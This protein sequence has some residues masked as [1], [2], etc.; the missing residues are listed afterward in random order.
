MSYGVE[1]PGCRKWIEINK[2]TNCCKQ[3][4]INM[5]YIMLSG[6]YYNRQQLRGCTGFDGFFEDGEAVRGGHHVKSPNKI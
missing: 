1:V 3:A 5:E 2:Q 4:G 6:I